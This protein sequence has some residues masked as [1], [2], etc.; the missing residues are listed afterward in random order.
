MAQVSQYTGLIPPLTDEEFA[1]LKADIAE[2]GVLIPV[3]VDENGEVLDGAHRLRAC[4]ELGIDCERVVRPG[5]S[6]DEKRDHAIA[7]NLARRHLTPEQRK[8]LVKRL[9]ADGWSTRRIA[10][11]AGVE[12]VTVRRDLAGATNDAPE[13]VVG[14]DGKSYPARRP[15][16]HADTAKQAERVQESLRHL[17]TDALP[18]GR[19][20][21]SRVER[22]A[23]REQPAR[24]VPAPPTGTYSVLYVDPPWRYDHSSTPE[25]RA[26]ENQYPTMTLDEL[27]ALP[28]PAAPDAVLFMWAT[29]PKLTE[30]LELM[31]AWSFEYRTCAAWVKDRIGM[32]YYFRQQH[33]L[34]LVGRRGDPPLPAES[35]RQPSVVTAPRGRHSEKPERF[36][37]L[38][39]AMYPEGPRIELFARNAREGWDSWGNEAQAA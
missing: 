20:E 36:Y 14:K 29:S 12:E 6:H 17:N 8:P 34:L 1:A 37:E 15:H 26:V 31:A 9:R 2:R 30:A 28:V 35:D 39:E 3:E 7:L 24:A 32:G 11:A 18:A 38:I 22:M 21:A 16:V 19:L 5:L 27:K 25:V 33:E 4:E 13:R 23:R 10:E